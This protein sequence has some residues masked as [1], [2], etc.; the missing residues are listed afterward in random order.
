M[1]TAVSIDVRDRVAP[2]ALDEVFAWFRRVDATFS[3]YQADSQISR[4]GR[5]EITVLDCDPDVGWV[6]EQCEEIRLATGGY[7]DCRP[8]GTLDP[9]GF[10]KGWSAEVASSMLVERGSTNHCINAGGDIRLRGEPAPGRPWHAGISH[11]LDPGRL[12][13][14]VAGRD[15]AVATSGTAERGQHV[16]DPL[17]GSPASELASVTLVGPELSLTDAYATAALAM[18]LDAVGWLTGLPDHDAYVIDAGGHV[19]WTAGFPRYAPALAD[20]PQPGGG[21]SR[22][23]QTAGTSG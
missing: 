20:L 16:V 21:R 13:V 19:W 4:L 23:D 10:V 14:V 12:T 6:L 22:T 9:S 8:T 17:T 7:F 11:P 2:D 18:G 5:G 1:G 15:I 3:T